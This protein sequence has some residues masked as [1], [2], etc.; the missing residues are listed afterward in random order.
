M[1]N[2]NF[3][4]IMSSSRERRYGIQ[5]YT[6]LDATHPLIG[7]VVRGSGDEDFVPVPVEVFR[8]GQV[9]AFGEEQRFAQGRP[10]VVLP[11]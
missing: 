3:F 5:P 1:T 8:G 4:R 9:G 2:A 11:G 7:T 10:S 6:L